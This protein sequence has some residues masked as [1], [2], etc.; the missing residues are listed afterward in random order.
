MEWFLVPSITAI[1]FKIVIFVRYQ[2]SLRKET[3]S[4]CALFL[5]VFLLNIVELIALGQSHSDA[6]TL[7]LLI[8][9]HCCAIF[10]VHAYLNIALE[11][12]GFSWNIK[13]VRLGL[14]IALVA[15]TLAL[16]FSRDLIA[17]SMVPEGSYIPTKEAGSLYWLFQMY[18]LA[19]MAFAAGLLVYGMRKLE[20]N[21]SRRQC[22]VFLL[23]SASPVIITTM[24]ITLQAAG[25]PLSSGIFMSLASTV[26]LGIIVYAEEKSRL[27]RLMTFM[28]YSSERKLHTQLLNQI[29]QCVSINDDP[30][31]KNALNLK[32]MMKALEGSVV[33][34]VLNYYEGNQ[35]MTAH[36]LGVS[37]ATLSRRVRS[38]S[39]R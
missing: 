11:Y 25:L 27:F 29:T 4:L 15:L 7:L 35:K 6:T 9:Y 13:N 38:A 10:I 1:I 18:T 26:M 31:T 23:A 20:S 32:D 8:A 2:D 37:E 5:A 28:P 39:T 21:Q 17:G 22:M 36:A 30:N 3:I 24:V 34:H 12:S 16:V 33:E 19:G 14:N